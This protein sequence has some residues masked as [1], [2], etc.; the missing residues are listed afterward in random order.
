MYKTK[1]FRLKPEGYNPQWGYK[2]K[3]L[4]T[5][6]KGGMPKNSGRFILIFLWK[7][8]YQSEHKIDKTNQF[9]TSTQ[10]TNTKS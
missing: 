3:A 1:S 5:V 9:Y 4:P 2:S 8:L 10:Q 7:N 6:Y